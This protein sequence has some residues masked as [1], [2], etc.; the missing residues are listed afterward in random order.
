MLLPVT[1]VHLPWE[2][3]RNPQSCSEQLLFTSHTFDE[4]INY[5]KDSFP[6]AKVK[7][8]A[9]FVTFAT[10]DFADQKVGPLDRVTFVQETSSALIFLKNSGAIPDFVPTPLP[11]PTNENTFQYPGNIISR[12]R[13]SSSL[14]A[15]NL[16]WVPEPVAIGRSSLTEAFSA[17]PWLAWDKQDR[18]IR[19]SAFFSFPQWRHL[20][21]SSVVLPTLLYHL[22]SASTVFRRLLASTLASDTSI[23]SK[24]LGVQFRQLIA[25]PLRHC[26]VHSWTIVV[27]IGIDEC[28]D[29]EFKAQLLD[30]ICDFCRTCP[31]ST[32]RWVITGRLNDQLRSFFSDPDFSRA[33]RMDLELITENWSRSTEASL[34]LKQGFVDIRRIFSHELAANL[35]WP[36]EKSF[37]CILTSA[38]GNLDVID[39]VLHFVA[40][41]SANNPRGRLDECVRVIESAGPP[42]SVEALHLLDLLFNRL[43]QNVAPENLPLVMQ[44]VGIAVLY[45]SQQYAFDLGDLIYLLDLQQDQAYELLWGLS[46]LINI[47]T[48]FEVP[49]HEIGTAARFP[50]QETADGSKRHMTGVIRHQSFSDFVMD[51][52]RSGKYCLR[53]GDIHFSVATQS[54]KWIKRIHSVDRLPIPDIWIDR[55]H[56]FIINN[57]WRACTKTPEHLTPILIR[58]LEEID[59]QKLDEDIL[60]IFVIPESFSLPTKYDEFYRWFH[61]HGPYRSLDHPRRPENWP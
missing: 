59:L 8:D 36:S 58:Q 35:A 6:S 43:L 53:D 40:D 5:T 29:S 46:P 16:I 52:R 24:G 20:S 27:L 22:A 2:N 9:E 56:D 12:W 42:G 32:M 38:S 14:F 51:P 57:I 33:R 61:R 28:S 50:S 17:N 10:D 54:L 55:V 47:P 45:P 3:K 4:R 26:R 49:D 18:P 7:P 11:L 21:D 15:G 37:R 48:P 34:V 31:T 30:L 23:F 19:V 25:K 1:N 41:A 13:N 39:L 44:I 60:Q